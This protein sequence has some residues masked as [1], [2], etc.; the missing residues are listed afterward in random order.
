MNTCVCRSSVEHTSAC[1]P[2]FMPHLLQFFIVYFK[3]EVNYSCATLRT[4]RPRNRMRGSD[5]RQRIRDHARAASKAVGGG[6]DLAI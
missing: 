1:D 2:P 5:Q 4:M 6:G 3:Y